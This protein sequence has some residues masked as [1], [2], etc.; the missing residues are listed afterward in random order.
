M[1]HRRRHEYVRRRRPACRLG[2]CAP[3]FGSRARQPAP[4]RR[5]HRGLRVIYLGVRQPESCLASITYYR[6]NAPKEKN[7]KQALLALARRHVNVLG[8]ADPGRSVP[9][10]LTS[11]HGRGLTS[12][13]GGPFHVRRGAAREHQGER[14]SCCGCARST[15]RLLPAGRV[16]AG[17]GAA[18]HRPARP[19]NRRP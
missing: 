1:T 5:F 12:R 7:H 18:G 14:P 10:L 16:P 13:L 8:T 11:R 2:P 6:R 4:L 15:H 17:T 9:P 3:W 19:P